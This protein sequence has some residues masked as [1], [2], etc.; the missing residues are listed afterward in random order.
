MSILDWMRSSAAPCACCGN[1]RNTYCADGD[2]MLVIIQNSA[3]FRIV[4]NNAGHYIGFCRTL[5]SAK[6]RAESYLRDAD[7]EMYAYL[8][9]CPSDETRSR[10]PRA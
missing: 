1:V 7:P 5:E 9:P 2:G 3:G 8:D 10:G 4:D 6:D